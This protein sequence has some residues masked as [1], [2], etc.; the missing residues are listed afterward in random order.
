MRGEER[1]VISLYAIP[2]IQRG[3]RVSDLVGE[4][5]DQSVSPC[6]MLTFLEGFWAI[7]P[8]VPTYILLNFLGILNSQTPTTVENR[9]IY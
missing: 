6:G 3:D 5:L 9:R 8:I 1:E 7:L 4:G 2:D